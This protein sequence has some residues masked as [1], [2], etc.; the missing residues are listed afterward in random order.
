M[1]VIKAPAFTG[2]DRFGRHFYK[3]QRWFGPT[4]FVGYREGKPRQRYDERRVVEPRTK[5]VRVCVVA[6]SEPPF[7]MV[8]D[9]NGAWGVR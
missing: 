6:T 3:G 8:Q 2:K 7:T 9:S 4:N 1:P 5:A